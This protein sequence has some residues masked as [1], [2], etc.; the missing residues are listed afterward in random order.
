MA[1]PITHSTCV[2][3]SSEEEASRPCSGS[4]M[5][6]FS[7]SV[8]KIIKPYPASSTDEFTVCIVDI[9]NEL[10]KPGNPQGMGGEEMG[11][12]K[13]QAMNQKK[14]GALWTRMDEE[15]LLHHLKI[16]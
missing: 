15:G 6:S 14:N 4:H 12:Q 1:V 10:D 8:D 5:P 2:F 16:T 3:R 11:C 7:R 9:L 13:F